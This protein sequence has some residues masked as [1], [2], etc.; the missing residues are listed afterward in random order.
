MS[1]LPYLNRLTELDVQRDG[2]THIMIEADN[3]DALTALQY[4]HENSVDVI[5]IDP[6]YNTGGSLTYRDKFQVTDWVAQIRPTMILAH[7]L[8][9]S[10]GVMMISIDDGAMRPHLD[11]MLQDIFGVE[12]SGGSSMIPG[13]YTDGYWINGRGGAIYVEGYF[14]DDV[15]N[16]YAT[17]TFWLSCEVN[18]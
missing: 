10:S 1:K 2:Q 18:F 7:S 3:K 4:S 6:P 11:L 16:S 14:G 15:M 17:D 12:N 9:K 13:I 8:L 5:Y